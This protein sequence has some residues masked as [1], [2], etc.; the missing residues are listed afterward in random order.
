MQGAVGDEILAVEDLHGCRTRVVAVVEPA[1]DVGAVV[2]DSG[3]EAHGG[4]R[5]TGMRRDDE[6]TGQI[7]GWR[8]GLAASWATYGSEHGSP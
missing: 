8:L 5:D 1:L 6:R 7:W 4:E 3:A 2:G